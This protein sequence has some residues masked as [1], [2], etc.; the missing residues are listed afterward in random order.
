MGGN[1]IVAHGG[2]SYGHH[3]AQRLSL[4]ERRTP[5]AVAATAISVRTLN[6]LVAEALFQE[7]VPV[8]PFSPC[9]LVHCRNGT[10]M[11]LSTLQLRACLASGLVPLLHGDVVFD[12]EDGIA[13]LSADALLAGLAARLSCSRVLLATNVPGVFA[14][15]GAA[16]EERRVLK[17]I[18]S[19][20]FGGTA[21]VTAET[22]GVD[23]TGG[24]LGKVQ[25][26][27]VLAKIRPLLE[28]RIFSAL[29][30][31]SVYRALAKRARVGTL[32][33]C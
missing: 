12:A 9:A 30:S 28:I 23:I 21:H 25:S 22:S 32:I 6:Q 24:M 11:R 29:P 15:A 33:T 18:S 8:V 16:R 17:S 4:L 19:K 1:L 2:E 31:D 13:V 5:H 10:I 14:D 7:G 3:V 27:M 26:M 20:S